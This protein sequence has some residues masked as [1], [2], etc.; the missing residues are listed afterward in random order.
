M[1]RKLQVAVVGAGPAGMFTVQSLVSQTDIPVEVTLIDRLPTP[2]GLLRYG[3]APDHQAMRRLRG[4]FQDVLLNASVRFVGNVEIGRQ[5]TCEELRECCDAV[6]YAYGAASDRQLDIPGER[7]SGNLSAREFVSW[8]CGH[9]DAASASIRGLLESS[10]SAVI[11]GAGNV[12]VDVSR[13]L[14]KSP[15]SLR[16]TEMPD[17][18][19][20]GLAASRITDVHLVARRG[21][22]FATFTTKELR[23][24]GELDDVA[25]VLDPRDLELDGADAAQLDQNRNAAR[26]LDVLRGWA[27]RADDR[28]SSRRIHL[29]FNT[30]PTAIAGGSRVSG[31]VT[32]STKPVDAAPVER[33]IRCELLIRAIG[34]KGQAVGDLPFDRERGTVRNE[35]GRVLRDGAVMPGEYV[36]GWIRRGPNGVIGTNKQDAGEV[37]DCL[38]AD[39]PQLLQRKSP[40]RPLAELLDE[41]DLL[42]IDARHWR[43]IEEAE[44]ALG[45]ARGCQR[46]TVHE[47]AGLLAPESVIPQASAG[48]T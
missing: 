46:I 16:S 41:R 34:Y 8:Y 12:A 18:V 14:L 32:S 33:P 13:I 40:G 47:W 20:E 38:I 23:E 29:H 4:Q 3:V 26:N 25:V 5:I 31:V 44:M 21:P 22:A 7:C 19:I 28:R 48:A 27:D 15:H 9:P 1:Q 37:V 17:H 2:F 35:C 10:H 11:I 45:R 36:T 42:R 24:L 39:A 6:I 43:R 30:R